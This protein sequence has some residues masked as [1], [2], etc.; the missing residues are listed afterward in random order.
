MLSVLGFRDHGL[1]FGFPADHSDYESGVFVIYD[2]AAAHL[3]IHFLDIK[4]VPGL[5]TDSLVKIL[6]SSILYI[7]QQVNYCRECQLPLFHNS[8]LLESGF[9]N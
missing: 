2:L 3:Y 1:W 7:I 4:V 9:L 8:I 6:L 5:F